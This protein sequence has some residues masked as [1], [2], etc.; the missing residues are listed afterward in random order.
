MFLELILTSC[1]G[2]DVSIFMHNNVHE[3]AEFRVNEMSM[4]E[5]VSDGA[6]ENVTRHQTL[7]PRHN[8]QSALV[9]T[10]ILN[11]ILTLAQTMGSILH[12]SRNSHASKTPLYVMSEGLRSFT[13]NVQYFAVCD[14][15]S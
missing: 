9:L 12:Y 14:K 13:V 1:P 4:C 10:F 3:V 5:I 15:V 11:P 7:R 2:V 6:M 8:S